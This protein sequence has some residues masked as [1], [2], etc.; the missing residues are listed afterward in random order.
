MSTGNTTWFAQ[1]SVQL[2][3]NCGSRGNTLAANFPGKGLMPIDDKLSAL[4]RS[5]IL[6]VSLGTI[7]LTQVGCVSDASSYASAASGVAAELQGEER[8][9]CA[10]ALETKSPS[11]VNAL[12]G[13]YPSSRCVVPLLRAMPPEVLAAL[14]PRAVRGLPPSVIRALPARIVAQLPGLSTASGDGAKR[15]KNS[16]NY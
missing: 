11:H 14:S 12:L 1:P 16:G 8:R 7:A 15:V 9:L 10:R 13:A 5:L 6:G 2:W 3:V 4:T